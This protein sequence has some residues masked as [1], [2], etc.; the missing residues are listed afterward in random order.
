MQTAKPGIPKFNIG[1]IVCMEDDFQFNPCNKVLSIGKVQ[2]IH[3]Y[4]G[5]SLTNRK[6]LDGSHK[7][8]DYRGKVTYTISGLSLRPDESKL[9][10]FD[11]TTLKKWRD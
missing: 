3:V 4:K 7:P 11:V 8:I 1:D 5:E 9:K 2:S 6:H 10:P